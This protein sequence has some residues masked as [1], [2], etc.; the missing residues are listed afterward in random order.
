MKKQ[1]IIRLVLCV[2]LY[3]SFIDD[4]FKHQY[5]SRFSFKKI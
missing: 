5:F 1:T 3:S 2:D 4:I